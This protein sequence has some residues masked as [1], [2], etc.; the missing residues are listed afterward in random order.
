MKIITYSKT[1][2]LVAVVLLL[3]SC[4]DGS[5]PNPND[6]KIDRLNW[7]YDFETVMAF[8]LF[9]RVPAIDET[10]N[11]YV[12]ADVQ[13]GGQII[14]LAAEGSEIWTITESEF[15][16][17]RLIYFENKLFYIVK[18]K[19]TCRSATDGS[20]LWTADAPGGYN[21]LALT[22]EKIYTNKFEDGGIFGCNNSLMAFDHS[23]NKTWETKIKYSDN[24]TITYPNAISVV[25]NNIYL[26]IFVEVGDSDFVIIN[27]ID[28]GNSVTKQWSWLAPK[29]YSVGGATP[30]IK[31]FAIDENS[32]LIFGMENSSTQY[33]FSVSPQGTENWRT[34]TSLPQIISNVTVNAN[35]DCFAAY[36]F[37]EK[38]NNNGT[39]WTS[40]VKADWQYEGLVS[41]AP[42]I[43]QNGNITYENMS[44][45]LAS[46]TPDGIY[47]WEQYWGC[48]L[49]NDEFHNLTINRN[50]DIIVVTKAGVFSFQGDGTGLSDNGWPKKYGDYGNTSSK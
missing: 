13:Y 45:I 16:L 42:V 2:L 15:P 25:G 37:V 34:A 20:E 9:N 27:F 18:N 22:S 12:A 32:N 8:S 33:V 48:E 19:L 7:S 21:T 39:I 4:D 1:I 36:N 5:L 11:I 35:D 14:K 3:H 10:G 30:R 23:G 47:E 50:G 29:D 49:C 24:D 17:S 46:V 41:K 26:G 6:N 28:E 43:S 40:E 31:D 38:I 44:K